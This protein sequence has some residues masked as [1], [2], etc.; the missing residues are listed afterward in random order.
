MTDFEKMVTALLNGESV[1]LEPNCRCEEY[2]KACIEGK[3][4]DSLPTPRSRMDILLWQLAEKASSGWGGG[5]EDTSWEITWDGNTEE[6]EILPEEIL[7]LNMYRVMDT[8]PD[9]VAK[10]CE[11]GDTVTCTL[12]P[13]GYE[14]APYV[15]QTTIMSYPVADGVPPLH[16]IVIDLGEAF[17]AAMIV[18][19]DIAF[20]DAVIPCGVYVNYS[21]DIQMYASR[22]VY[23]Y[24]SPITNLIERSISVVDDEKV[25]AVGDSAF[26]NCGML[27]TVRLPNCVSLGDNAF[28][29]CCALMSLEVAPD[30][31]TRLPVGVFKYCYSLPPLELNAVD[32][33]GNEA[34]LRVEQLTELTLTDKCTFIGEQACYKCH[35]LTTVGMSSS[36][37]TIMEGAFQYCD[38]LATIDLSHVTKIYEY[39]F[40]G[41]SSLTSVNLSLAVEIG[42]H[43]FA[44]CSN[45]TLAGMMRSIKDIGEYAF[46]GCA[47]ISVIDT[48]YL[49]SI[50]ALAFS[51]CNALTTLVI[52]TEYSVATLANVDAF[53]RTPI[54]SGTGY[55]YVPAALVE[56][57][58]AATNWSTYANQ[59]RALEDYTVDGTTTGDLDESKIST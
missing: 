29:S 25:T 32:F 54:A 56:E 27:T 48:L 24:R 22:I 14:S 35:A 4:T 40:D 51:G 59:F 15:T 31:L 8:V 33:I 42:A 10:S 16:I 41:C 5:E 17:I 44:L 23:E 58:K 50:G 2:L 36:V 46:I 53:N 34:L 38:K 7:G 47:K 12:N 1:D 45:I 11:N 49:S 3:G 30:A 21:S 18:L 26:K 9:A 28:S 55:I 39:A 52:R 19:N 20:G 43:A 57:Y 13:I 37:K 6:T